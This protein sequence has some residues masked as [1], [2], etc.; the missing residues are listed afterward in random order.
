MIGI[1]SETLRDMVSDISGRHGI[2]DSM[3]LYHDLSISGDDAFEL[4]DAIHKNFG[5]VFT[6]FHFESYFPNE[7]EAIWYRIGKVFGFRDK[8][9]R[10]TFGHLLEV[11][12][13]GRWFDPM[14]QVNTSL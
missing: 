4:L 1:G 14:M 5:T 3:C 2:V 7:T 9:K 8:K 11:T 6:D 12:K 13:V 10:L